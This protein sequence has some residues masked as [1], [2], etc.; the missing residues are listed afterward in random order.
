MATLDGLLLYAKQAGGLALHVQAGATPRLR[1]SGGLV[2]IDGWP[3]LD[4]SFVERMRFEIAPD[5]Q[6]VVCGDVDGA[7]FRCRV[8]DQA[9]GLSL[10]FRII[11]PEPIAALVKS[12]TAIAHQRDGF[13]V[14]AGRPGSGRTTTLAAIATAAVSAGRN[15]VSIESHPEVVVAGM[16]HYPGARIADAV[17]MDADVIIAGDTDASPDGHHG[18]LIART[19]LA[20]SG[21]AALAALGS[22]H[23][24]VTA[25]VLQGSQK[26]S[27]MLVRNDLG[28]RLER[29]A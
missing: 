25:L 22:D 8:S 19:V 26:I 3:S 18:V 11:H 10:A 15:V 28:Q 6:L 12:L 21:P 14:V 13:A 2:E 5:D 7:R 4:A 20:A 29:A 24:R 1:V 16:R 27:E 17:R 9:D 23:D